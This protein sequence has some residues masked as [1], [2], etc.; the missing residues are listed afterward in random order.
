MF[1]CRMPATVR[2][3]LGGLALLLLLVAERAHPLRR[4]TQPKLHRAFINLGLAGIGAVV[5]WLIYPSVVLRSADFAATEKLGLLRALPLPPW[6]QAPLSF[7]LLDYT[8]WIWHWLNHRVPLF[9]RFHAAHHADQNMDATTGLRFHWG[10]LVFSVP[11]RGLQVLLLGVSLPCLCAWEA[12]MLVSVEFHHS[13][14]RLPVALERRLRF[15][16]VTPRMHGIH[17]SVVAAQLN[18]NYGTLFSFWDRLHG[19]FVRGVSQRLLRVGLEGV[20]PETVLGFWA[21]LALP[22]ARR[23]P[24][25]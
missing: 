2:L 11:Y 24:E 14:V 9:W 20:A 12:V 17:H 16:I 6:V 18:S 5:V 21:S 8:L 23:R 4:I 3:V 25:R 13:N 19:T 22:F 10:E 7:L 1:A 15:V